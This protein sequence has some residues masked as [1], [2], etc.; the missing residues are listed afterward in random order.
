MTVTV[1]RFWTA[2]KSQPPRTHVEQTW[3]A[4]VHCNIGG[5]YK[6]A[7][8]SD[9]ALIWMIARIQALTDLEFDVARVRA[10]TR[11]NVNGEVVDSSE[12]WFIDEK[13]RVCADY[14]G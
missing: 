8:L 9:Q 3:F 2:P 12:G 6:D 4:G 5:G 1:L 11:P 13:F 10:V 14:A 7:G